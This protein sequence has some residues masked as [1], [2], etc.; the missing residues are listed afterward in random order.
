MA[1]QRRPALALAAGALFATGFLATPKV[2]Y[3]AAL[4]GLLALADG[5]LARDLRWPRDIVRAGLLGVTAGIVVLAFQSA[6]GH[7]FPGAAQTAGV[8]GSVGFGHG[9][10]VF[11]GELWYCDAG[12]RD[13]G[14]LR[15]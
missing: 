7:A 14:I 13:I 9:M 12:T 6:I 11:D 3:V 8:R 4:A 2:V 1:S 5:L 15:R 10:T